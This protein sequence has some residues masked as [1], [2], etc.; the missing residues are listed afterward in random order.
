MSVSQETKTMGVLSRLLNPSPQPERRDTSGALLA[1]L[2]GGQQSASGVSV[3]PESSLAYSAVL[4]CVRVLA[5]GVA[6]LPLILYER[7]DRG[8]Q[9]ATDHPLSALLH[10]SPNP[11]ITSFEWREV[12]MAHLTLWGNAF[13]EIERNGAGRPLALWPLL[14]ANMTVHEKDGMRWYEYEMDSGRKIPMR[15]DQ[16]LHVPGFG[17]DGLAGKSLIRLA[18]ESV[19]LGIAAGRYGAAVFG[20]GEVPGGV[21]EHPGVLGDEA[22]KHLQAS[23]SARHQGLTNA[24]RLAILEE[25]MKYTKTGVPP[26]DAQFLET[27]RFQRTEIAAIFRVPPHMIGDLERATFSNI[28]QQSLDFVIYTIGPWLTRIEQRLNMSLLSDAERP[29]YYAEH[30]V[31]GLLRGDIKARFDAYAVARGW[32]WMSANDVRE[33]ENQNPVDGGDTYLVPMN[34]VDAAAGPVAPETTPADQPTR[35]LPVA[36]QE[37]AQL[38]EPQEVRELRA[39]GSRRKLAKSYE[40]TLK[41]V[42]QRIVNRE[43]NDIRNA[44]RRY[45]ARAEPDV[46]GFT[47]WLDDFDNAHTRFVREYLTAPMRTYGNLVAMEVERETGKDVDETKV[48]RFMTDYI[49][50]RTGQWMANLMRGIRQ[51]MTPEKEARADKPQASTLDRVEAELD[52]RQ[53]SQ[54]DWFSSEEAVRANNAVALTIYALIGILAKRWMSFGENCPYCSRLNGRTVELSRWFLTQGEGMEVQG[55]QAWKS[56]SDIGHPPLH[57][58]CDCMIVGV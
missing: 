57:R 23:W 24:N 49:D 2:S 31:A 18:R 30:L 38:P 36:H 28:E 22:F 8:R 55:L 52:D 39:A 54:A 48:D 15:S 32:G 3:T 16:V 43:V 53:A 7:Q 44:A 51:A 19:G 29:R 13:C 50:G 25:G 34:M 1:M 6:Q 26:E 17:Y 33:L 56:G 37:V 9:R 47:N 11:V 58:G 46:A 21:L 42:S 41:H 10:T 40:G 27:R 4:A 20:S 14:P 12:M 35:A 5:E 45:L